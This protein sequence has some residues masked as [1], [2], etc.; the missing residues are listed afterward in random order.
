MSKIETA[1]AKA[2]AQAKTGDKPAQPPADAPLVPAAMPADAGRAD[3]GALR[4]GS[5]Q[6]IGRM[7]EPGLLDPQALTQRRIIHQQMDDRATANSFRELRTKILQKAPR[8]CT[9][10]V[11]S[12][13]DGG[14]NSFV[15][16][17]L[18]VAFALDDS[19]T[20]LLVDG[21]LQHPR[22]DGLVWGGIGRGVT[23]FLQDERLS[24]EEIIHPTGIPRLRLVPVG[25]S[26]NFVAEYFTADRFRFLLQGLSARYTDRYVI[27]D[28]PP[29]LQSADARA[30]AEVADYVLLVVPYGKMTEAQV[31]AAARMIEPSKLLGAV[32]N[33]VPSLPTWN[34]WVTW[35]SAR[36][37]KGARTKTKS[38]DG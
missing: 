16:L 23:D 12:G 11:T 17:N 13:A 30:L 26:H 1:L 10:M 36:W 38:S 29:I 14:G 24:V 37:R 6:E 21:N 31:V 18:A 34:T 20:A 8:G 3:S 25:K 2:R 5:R 22:F 19:K 15:A 4:T 27:I 28:A 7:Q 35:L 9:I 33:D 32:F